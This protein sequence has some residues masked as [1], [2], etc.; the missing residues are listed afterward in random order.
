MPKPRPKRPDEHKSGFLIRLPEWCRP[1]MAA[2][3]VKNRRPT[4]VE[5]LIAIEKHC[6][7]E[8]VPVPKQPG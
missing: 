2:L 3:K 1:A 6:A 4:T 8:G 7:A 5:V